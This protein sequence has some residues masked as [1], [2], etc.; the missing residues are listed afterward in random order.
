[1]RPVSFFRASSIDDAVAA[2][3]GHPDSAFLAGGTTEIDLLRLGVVQPNLLVDVND[4]PLTYLE[5]I[6]DGGVRIGAMARMSDVAR[7]PRIMERYPGMSQALL[8]GASEQLRNMASMGGNMCQRTRCSY[9]RDPQSSCN[10]REPGT[11]CAAMNGINRG[12]AILGTSDQCIAT[13]PSDVAVALVALDATVRTIGPDGTRTIPIE[14]F[15]LRPE[16]TPNIEHPLAHGELIVAIDVPNLPVAR[17]SRYVKHRDRASYEFAL[18]SVFSAMRV[19]DGTVAEL[20]L[21]LGGVGTVPW[22]AHRAE[23]ALVGRPATPENVAAAAD[24]ELADART[25]PMNA[26]KVTFAKRAIVRELSEVTA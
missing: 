5:D 22:R 15:F 14:D 13:H 8:L 17:A 12:H 4:L 2:V 20:R 6:D 1:M 19:E 3:S 7:A 24:A 10:K 16:D 25:T 26:F 23:A 9:F 21:A 18:V 11:G